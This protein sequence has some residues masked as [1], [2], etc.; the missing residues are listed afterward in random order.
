MQSNLRRWLAA[1][2]LAAALLFGRSA[3][4][5]YL[6]MAGNAC[7]AG[8][9]GTKIFQDDFGAGNQSTTSGASF[10][11]PFNMGENVNYYMNIGTVFLQYWDRST[12]DDFACYIYRTITTGS[13][14]WG[15]TWHS[16]SAG[17]TGWQGCIDSTPN[18][19]STAAGWMEWLNSYRGP[20]TQF[21]IG[22]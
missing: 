1:S 14:Y 11:C 22:D 3:L 8:F 15:Q 19:S 10:I 7:Q 20:I 9:G 4:A 6:G 13:Q 5:G 17:P 12:T 18:Y 21:W 2:G 16:C